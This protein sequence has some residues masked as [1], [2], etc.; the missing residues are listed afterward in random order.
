MVEVPGVGRASHL[1]T[2]DIWVIYN[3][4]S[5]ILVQSATTS[6]VYVSRDGFQEK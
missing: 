4:N 3:D 5:Q 2:G 6:V 1:R